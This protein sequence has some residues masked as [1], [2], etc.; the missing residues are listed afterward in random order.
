M[1]HLNTK[2]NELIQYWV[3][4]YRRI[5][6]DPP[7]DAEGHP[8]WGIEADEAYEANEEA[9]QKLK[10]NLSQ[11]YAWLKDDQVMVY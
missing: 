9:Y 5:R 1:E 10:T 6:V 7:T 2:W 4:D 11:A 8:L 3:A